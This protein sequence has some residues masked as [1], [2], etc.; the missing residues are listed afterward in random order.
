MTT[1]IKYLFIFLIFPSITMAGVYRDTYEVELQR[2][3]FQLQNEVARGNATK[4]EKKRKAYLEN[5]LNK[6]QTVGV[7]R[8]I[9]S[10]GIN[11][12]EPVDSITS[13]SYTRGKVYLFTEIENM[14]G[15]YITHIWY[16][17]GKQ[18]FKKRVRI[19]GSSRRIW[20]S[21]VITKNMVGKWKGVI[22]NDTGKILVIKYF[23]ITK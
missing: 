4:F 20:T 15:K 16:F 9:F 11:E 23:T 17:N 7:A 2:E 22:V 18:A 6:I 8:M 13:I 14:S 19:K 3:I 12:S 21:K 10:T 5:R 1:L